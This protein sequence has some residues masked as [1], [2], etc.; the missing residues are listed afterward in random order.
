MF[1]GTK[2]FPGN[3]FQNF[4]MVNGGGSI[5]GSTTLDM[6]FYPQA[7]P[8]KHLAALMELEA[9]RMVNLQLP[10]DQVTPELRVVA[11]ERRGNENSPAIC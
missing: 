5:N 8:S 3:Y 9:D 7:C 6:T 1:K 4:T 2:R 10:E 11:N